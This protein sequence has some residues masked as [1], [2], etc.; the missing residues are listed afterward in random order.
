[1]RPLLEEHDNRIQA[2]LD[3]NP[4][5]SR[6]ALEPQIHAISDQTHHEIEALLTEY[7]K[8]LAKTMEKRMHHAA[9]NK[10]PSNNPNALRASEANVRSTNEDLE[11]PSRVPG[12]IS[13]VGQPTNEVLQAVGAPAPQSNTEDPALYAAQP[14]SPRARL[15]SEQADLRDYIQA[16]LEDARELN[17]TTPGVNLDEA[18]IGTSPEA[19]IDMLQSRM[20]KTEIEPD[21]LEDLARHNDSYANRPRHSSRP[22]EDQIAGSGRMVGTNRPSMKVSAIRRLCDHCLGRDDHC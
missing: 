15:K 2:L 13:V 21:A 1:M 20:R 4:T 17:A 5:V 12:L 22:A 16:L 3:K 10:R 9:E 6:E 8:Q 11:Q 7:Q 19:T 14:A 18:D